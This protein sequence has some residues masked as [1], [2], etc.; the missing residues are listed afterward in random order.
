MIGT[1]CRSM[2]HQDGRRATVIP[3]CGFVASDFPTDTVEQQVVNFLDGKTNGENLLH[4][5]YD[6]I[7]DEPIPVRLSGLLKT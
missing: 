5:L 6:Y 2:Q 7:L 3:L 4:L 1:R